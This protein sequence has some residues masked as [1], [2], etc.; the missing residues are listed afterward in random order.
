[1]RLASWQAMDGATARRDAAPQ[2]GPVTGFVKYKPIWLLGGS[3]ASEFSK[4][5]H[6]RKCLFLDKFI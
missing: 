5:K 1:M 2:P 6:C 4:A 3:I